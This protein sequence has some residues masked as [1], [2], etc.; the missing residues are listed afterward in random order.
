MKMEPQQ[1]RIP[2]VSEKMEVMWTLLS[3]IGI[4]W[5]VR[6]CSRLNPTNATFM[7]GSQP[8][9]DWCIYLNLRIKEQT[10]FEMEEEENN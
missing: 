2:L 8:F 9:K 7:T 3:V 5:V 4:I 10:L 1:S 6:I